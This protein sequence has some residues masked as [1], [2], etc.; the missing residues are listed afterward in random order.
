MY[1][2]LTTGI[3]IALSYSYITLHRLLHHLDNYGIRLSFKTITTQLIL[4]ALISITSIVYFGTQIKFWNDCT[5]KDLAKSWASEITQSLQML[6]IL[7]WRIVTL[8][9]CALIL[10]Q[11]R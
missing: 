11:T 4:L 7:L 1:T 9:M 2:T 6:A 10:E 8:T 3:V 5:D